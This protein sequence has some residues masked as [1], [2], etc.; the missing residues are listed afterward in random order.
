MQACIPFAFDNASGHVHNPSGRPI[1]SVVRC[2]T[3]NLPTQTVQQRVGGSSA[4]ATWRIRHLPYARKP[5]VP[6]LRSVC[7]SARVLGRIVC[8]ESSV[9]QFAQ[10]GRQ[11]IDTVRA[12]TGCESPIS[13]RHL[14]GTV[15]RAKRNVGAVPVANSRPRHFLGIRA[16]PMMSSQ[17]RTDT[18]ACCGSNSCRE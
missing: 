13:S 15:D 6:M 2:N 12:S 8:S 18:G 14:R 10:R 16:A 11:A 4:A 7:R 1:P 3:H 9:S 5:A 17:C